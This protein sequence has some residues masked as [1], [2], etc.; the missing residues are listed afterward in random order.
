MA[1]KHFFDLLKD[2]TAELRPSEIHR[3]DDWAA[4]GERLNVALPQK[5]RKR[6]RTIILPLLLLSALLL[7]NAAWWQSSRSD[8]GDMT[9]LEVQV[10][11][12]QASF[13]A[14]GATRGMVQS[15][16]LH[17]TLWRTV[18]VRQVPSGL[19]SR[20]KNTTQPRVVSEARYTADL[21]PTG[22]R[23]N[24]GLTMNGLN[25][26]SVNAV[27]QPSSRSQKD[28][29][30]IVVADSGHKRA[31]YRS[32]T[33]D[34]TTQLADFSVLKI[35]RIALLEIPERAIRLPQIPIIIPL[36]QETITEPFGRSLLETLRPKF[37]KLGGN[38]GWL[39]A[40]SSGLMHEGGFSYN[41]HGE[42]GLTRHWSV[43][44]SFGMGR[45]H[46]K[47]HTPEAILGTPDFPMLPNMDQ[48]FAELDVTGQKNRQFDAGL[49][50]TFAQPGKPRPYLGLG[51]GGQTLL[52]FTVA[53][54]IQHEPTGVIQKEVFEVITRT[55]LRNMIS[56]SAGLDIP[57]AP[58]FDLTIEGFY[59]RQWKKP[60]SIAPDL[61]GVRA[62]LVWLF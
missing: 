38:I 29:S 57:L 45:L 10:A 43:T 53:Y 36:K 31:D 54:E 59:Q 4:M 8:Q 52:P 62:G 9:R 40:S 22:L 61:T 55:Q 39:Y 6:Q 23:R 15:K 1:D 58:R 24:P 51:W 26:G 48:H 25:L 47:A 21:A 30:E 50:Y 56:L 7:S 42:M 12:L 2:K 37:F 14:L 33:L 27:V 46:Y 32:S 60:S 13:A 44:A 16:V 18:Y 28:S 34:S 41:L 49:R 11:D 35:P 3:S 20:F 5:P 19:E 17:D